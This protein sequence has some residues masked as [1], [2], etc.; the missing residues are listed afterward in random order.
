MMNLM[1]RIQENSQA[2]SLGFSLNPDIIYYGGKD[3]ER[4][5]LEMLVDG[6]IL[7]VLCLSSPLHA[8]AE[9]SSR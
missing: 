5:I 1:C 4:K 7:N 9:M 8:E 6:S 2:H 3:V